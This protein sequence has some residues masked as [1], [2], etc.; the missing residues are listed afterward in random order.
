MIK[1]ETKRSNPVK[2]LRLMGC[3]V[4]VKHWRF[5]D[6]PVLGGVECELMWEGE[7]MDVPDGIKPNPRGGMTVT[8]ITTP[9]GSVYR[10]VAECSKR[11]NYCKRIGVSYC[12]DRLKILHKV[13]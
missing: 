3:E 8:T 7:G 6:V 4:K 11:D 2:A 12:L 5:Y 10:G 1:T 13:I 9:T